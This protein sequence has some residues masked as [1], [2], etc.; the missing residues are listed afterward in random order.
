MKI[1][2]L[3]G[4]WSREREV[5]L[6]SG[7]NVYEAL[8]RLGYDA[9]C[10]DMQRN[11]EEQVQGYDMVF[12]MLHG[13]PGEDGRLQGYLDLKGI[14]YVGSGPLASAI[15]LDKLI[16]KRL[17]RSVGIDIAPFIYFDSSDG[18]EEII[19]RTKSLGDFPLII[20]P[21]REGSSIDTYI[22]RS[23]E[24][25]EDKV[26]LLKSTYGD[27]IVEK[28]IKGRELTIG[29]LGTGDRAFALP[30]LELIPVVSEFYDYRA[31]Y[32][33]GGTRFVLPAPMPENLYRRL[34]EVAVHVHR[35]VGAR[36]FSRVDMILDESDNYY[37]LEINT[38]PGMTGTSD[39]PAQ[40]RAYGMGFDEL[41][42]F[43]VRSALER[44]KNG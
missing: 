13:N 10:V 26:N 40:A 12:I 9:E 42:D 44:D 34:Q 35:V 11:F 20:K 24:E 33:K 21:V 15:G 16:F 2:V 19:E 7:R 1:C 27:G 4:G 39:L 31:K 18:M 28:F 22:I 32:T 43:L 25:L 3:C 41:V 36:D 8:R 17:M 6:R 14:K 23:E 5:S 30:I 37:V 38:I 29:V